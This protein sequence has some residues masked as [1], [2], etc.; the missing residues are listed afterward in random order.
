MYFVRTFSIMRTLGVRLIAIEKVRNYGDVVFIQNMFQNGCWG[1]V[2][3]HLP[4]S[5]P[6][7]TNNNVYSNQ[8]VWLRY[9][10]KQILSQLFWNNSTYCTCTVWTLHFKKKGS[11]SKGGGFRPRNPSRVRHW[12]G[13]LFSDGVFDAVDK[14][15]IISQA[16]GHFCTAQIKVIFLVLPQKPLAIKQ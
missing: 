1:D 3:P 2:S 8:P 6:A 16:R 12:T 11:V 9:A 7:R 13:I 5:A 10:V 15:V 4:G 14:F